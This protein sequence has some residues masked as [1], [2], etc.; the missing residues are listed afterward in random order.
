MSNTQP[1]P[2]E[3]AR[4]AEL[5]PKVAEIVPG[6][7][8][9]QAQPTSVRKFF[10]FKCPLTGKGKTASPF[11]PRSFQAVLLALPCHVVAKI[12][13]DL[14][15]PNGVPQIVWLLTPAGMLSTYE[16]LVALDGGA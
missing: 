16:A 6:I 12:W 5:A 3:L 13:G 1:T 2:T 8:V 15:P 14:W 7:E 4:A 9:W 10:Q 11:D